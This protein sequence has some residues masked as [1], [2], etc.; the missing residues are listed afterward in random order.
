MK[1]TKWGLEV[2][3]WVILNE[4]ARNEPVVK[5]PEQLA[6]DVLRSVRV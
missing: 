6:G 2:K 1:A 4:V 5:D 3:K